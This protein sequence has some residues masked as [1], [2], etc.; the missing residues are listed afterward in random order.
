MTELAAL[1]ATE[2]TRRLR[3]RELGSVELLQYYQR[4]IET[5]NPGINAIVSTDFAAAGERAREADAALARG[6]S[7]GPLH[8][9]PITLKDNIET[10]G[11]P[12]TYGVPEYRDHL[13][14][15]NADVA[16]SLLDAGAVLFGKTNMPA[17]GMDTQTYNEVFGQSNNPW[18]HKRTPGGS[19]GGA[20]AAVAA[21]LT[22][23]EIGNDIGGSIRLPAHFCGIYGHK[24][25][26]G[27]VSMYGPKPW[28]TR[29]PGYSA[30]VDLLVNGPLARSAADLELVMDL[31]AGPPLAQRGAVTMRMPASRAESMQDFRVGVWLDEPGYEPDSG[32]GGVLQGLVDRLAAAGANIVTATPDVSLKRVTAM[33]N[34][35]EATTLAYTCP[36]D[37][38]ES[39][40]AEAARAPGTTGAKRT[41][42]Q[43]VTMRYRDWQS[44][45]RERNIMRSQW[46]DYFAGVDVLLCPVSRIAAH[47]HDTTP[48]PERTADF[49]GQPVHYWPLVGPWNSLALVAYLPATVAPAGV[50]AQGL[51]VGVQIIGPYY[52][53]R[54]PIRFAQALQEELLGAF[55]LPE[56]YA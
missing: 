49:D 51:P 15:S 1:S 23:L 35:L 34:E 27:L 46:H 12:T 29:H 2:L 38:Y 17:H 26:Y 45:N 48:I 56:G 10:V 55:E 33:R 7:W 43:S 28:E 36:A 3:D 42:A 50:T 32:V 41:W 14:A 30:D 4:R 9:L 6:E 40:L 39:A 20:A 44:I 13:A 18:N 25:S 19:S 37:A 8:G 54:T 22:G 52:Q 31:V 53:D 47:T 5:L 11:L 21:G 24:S 16:Q